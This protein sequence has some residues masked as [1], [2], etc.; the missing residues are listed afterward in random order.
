MIGEAGILDSR[1]KQSKRGK[2]TMEKKEKKVEV[3][4]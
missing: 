3:Q 4:E 2:G 1:E